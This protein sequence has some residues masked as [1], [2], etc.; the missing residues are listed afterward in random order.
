MSTDE[1]KSAMYVCQK[2]IEC[3]QT[4]AIVLPLSAATQLGSPIPSTQLTQRSSCLGKMVRHVIRIS[5]TFP[6]K[7]DHIGCICCCRYPS[8]ELAEKNRQLQ[9]STEQRTFP[10]K[11]QQARFPSP[12]ALRLL[13]TFLHIRCPSGSPS[14]CILVKRFFLSPKF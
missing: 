4:M 11:R 3:G 1:Y 14:G 8:D 10:N 7:Q 2:H 12:S 6:S 5:L 9:I 13:S